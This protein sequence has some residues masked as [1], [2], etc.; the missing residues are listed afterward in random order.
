MPCMLTLFQ[1]NVEVWA[2]AAN[3]RAARTTHR[4]VKAGGVNGQVM[5]DSLK[6]LKLFDDDLERVLVQDSAGV[7]GP[8]HADGDASLFQ[9]GHVLDAAYRPLKLA[10]MKS[11]FMRAMTSSL[12]SLG[13]TASHRPMLVQLPKSSAFACATMAM[14]R[15]ARSG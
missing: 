6:P 15:S 5:A 9:K 10:R 7:R 3:E 1:A 11:P 2:W 8:K 4:F 12:I 14:A 13:Q